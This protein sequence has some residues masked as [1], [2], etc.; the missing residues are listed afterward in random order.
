MAKRLFLILFSF[1]MAGVVSLLFI[2]FQ[3]L[4]TIA[5]E[6]V[7]ADTPVITTPLKLLS[8]VQPGLILALA[9]FVGV[10]LAHRVGLSAPFA[11]ALAGGGN[12]WSALKR[13]VLAGLVGGL[14]GGAAVVFVSL[15][16][17]YFLSS[18]VLDR[19]DKL[20]QVL[21]LPTRLLYGGITEEVLLRWGFMTLLVWLGWRVLQRKSHG[22]TRG[23]FVGAIVLSSVIFGIGH[24][25]VAFF[26]IPQVTVALI[27][28]VIIANSIFGLIAGYLYWRK[29]LEAAVLAHMLAHLVI[30]FGPRLAG[31]AN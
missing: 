27:L 5:P 31:T 17:R 8:L 7:S 30:V 2:D 24:L 19:I 15:L 16:F 11:E 13:Q 14:I 22:P 9:V 29:G 20:G 18:E 1:G 25:P 3:A 23:C 21:P 10:K 12:A 4:M 28:N 26:L 6:H